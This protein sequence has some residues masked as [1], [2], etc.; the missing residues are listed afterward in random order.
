MAK[1]KHKKK[2]KADHEPVI[3][4]RKARHR[5]AID[6]SLEVGVRLTGTE[7]KA[8]RTGKVSLGEGY[9]TATA[10]PLRLTLLG[11]HIGE[12]ENASAAF[13]HKPV[14]PREL[15][16]HKREIEKLAQRV[17]VKG[18]T[19]VPLRMYFKNN[20]IKLEL[21]IAR[22]KSAV[23]KREDIKER[24]MQRDIDRAMSKRI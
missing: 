20:L 15:L 13:Q 2:G 3:V 12:Y 16:A 11:V 22:G 10:S 21:G 6:D 18:V 8:V 23:D 1:T 14:R 4:N 7:V 17:Q 24:E 19:L 9:I 5:Y